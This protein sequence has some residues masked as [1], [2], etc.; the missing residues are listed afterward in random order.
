MSGLWLKGCL[1]ESKGYKVLRVIFKPRL[2]L[3]RKSSA[4]P[5]VPKEVVVVATKRK[6]HVENISF[7]NGAMRT[8]C[9]SVQ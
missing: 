4:S 3:I 2:L 5:G 9:S 6:K 1:N 8:H 7:S